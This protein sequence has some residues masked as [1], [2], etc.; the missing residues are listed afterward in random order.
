VK[1]YRKE[2]KSSCLTLKLAEMPNVDLGLAPV[3][4]IANVE[5][6]AV[7]LDALVGLIVNVEKLEEPGADV[8]ASPGHVDVDLAVH[9]ETIVNVERPE[10]LV[11]EDADV[12]DAAVELIANVERTANVLVAQN[13]ALVLIALARER[14]RRAL[15][16]VLANA[17]LVDHAAAVPSKFSE[18]FH[19]IPS[20]LDSNYNMMS[21]QNYFLKEFAA[22]LNST[23]SESLIIFS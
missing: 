6:G 18:E 10:P 2:I 22:S 23:R 7:A 17:D 4:P 16:N 13:A 15:A 20:Q 19:A 12:L 21:A 9:V 3:D 1:N 14:P 8:P 5:K 11:L